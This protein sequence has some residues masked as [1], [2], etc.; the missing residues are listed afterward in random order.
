M[1][2]YFRI[3]GMSSKTEIKYR[4]DAVRIASLIDILRYTTQ[5]FPE[6]I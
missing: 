1:V 2:D 5:F 6:E 4:L 3:E